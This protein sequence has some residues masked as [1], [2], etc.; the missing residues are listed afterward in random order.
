MGTDCDLYLDWHSGA[1]ND[2]VTD[3]IA[4]GSC[5]PTSPADVP[6]VSP[7]ST[8]TMMRI[9]ADAASPVS[10]LVTCGGV[11]Y[12]FG[13]TTQG[14]IYDHN[15][16]YEDVVHANVS[17]APSV[18]SMGFMFKT[19]LDTAWAWHAFGGMNGS[20]EW[21]LLATRYFDSQ[22]H[23]Y[24]HTSQ[25]Y[26]AVTVDINNDTW[27]WITIQYNRTAG[28]AYMEVYLA[29]TMMKVG[30]TLSLAFAGSPPAVSYWQIGQASDQG[31]AEAAYSWHGPAIFDWTDGTF[32]LLP[33]AAGGDAGV[34]EGSVGIGLAPNA[35][36]ADLWSDSLL[37][38][39][40]EG[41][42]SLGDVYLRGQAQPDFYLGLYKNSSEPGEAA[43][44]ADIT[45]ASAPGT[46]GYARIQLADADWTE[47]A[48]GTFANVLKTFTCATSA[49]GNVHGY[50]ITTTATGISGK[51]ITVEHFTDGPYD[52]GIED[53][54]RITPRVTFT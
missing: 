46:N 29:S 27:Y 6:Q 34:Y 18:M 11:E 5:R 54:V 10:G 4:A 19:T 37:K 31:N 38:W 2:L 32:P 25:G 20:A 14:V 26:S 8:L 22:Q 36:V 1:D 7:G 40:D 30:S 33:S 43:T 53:I 47:A 52:V 42:T 17:S 15:G 16:L 50:F 39:C 24:L 28:Y 9:E 35:P 23:L 49:W 44:M 21:A 41:E 3:A 12:D 13:D 51:L 48:Q 45:E